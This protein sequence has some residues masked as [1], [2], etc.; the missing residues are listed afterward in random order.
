LYLLKKRPL[1]KGLSLTNRILIIFAH[2]ALEKSRV[3]YRLLKAAQAVDGV[4]CRDLYQLYPD[5]MINV[6][7]EQQLLTQHEIILFQFPLYWYST[8]AILKEWQDLVLEYGFAYGQH[9]F[10]LKGKLLAN[11]LSAGG[12]RSSYQ[13]EGVNYFTLRELLRPLEQTANLC[14][15]IYLPPFVIH[16]ANDLSET[17]IDVYAS[18]Y[19]QLLTQLHQQTL[20]LQALTRLNYLNDLSV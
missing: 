2:P 20:D 15:M 1:K 3:Q 16:Q 6:A 5:F 9:G 17:D 7:E 12:S 4:T 10:A 19:Q 18:Q 8:P 13:T 11:I 14:G